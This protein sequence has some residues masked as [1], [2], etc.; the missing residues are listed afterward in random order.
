MIWLQSN[1]QRMRGS[2]QGI[3]SITPTGEAGID[4]RGTL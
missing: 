2:E 1:G 4:F 3:R